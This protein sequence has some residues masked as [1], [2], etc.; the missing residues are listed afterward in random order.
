[1]TRLSFSIVSIFNTGMRPSRNPR[2]GERA[3]CFDCQHDD[4]C[5]QNDQRL[6][7]GEFLKIHDGLHRE[8]SYSDGFDTASLDPAIFDGNSIW[9]D[10][11][12][13]V[14]QPLSD[15]ERNR[16]GTG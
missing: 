8:V 6:C 1:M 7:I 9:P 10:P 13:S 14:E 15:C 11:A 12:I 4:H 5:A 2:F 16:R 3:Q